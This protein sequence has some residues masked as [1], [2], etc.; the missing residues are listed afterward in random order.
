MQ[1]PANHVCGF[2]GLEHWGLTVSV[3]GTGR[4]T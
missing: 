1:G 3:A 2:D 4:L